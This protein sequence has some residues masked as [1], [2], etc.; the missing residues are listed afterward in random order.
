MASS[1]QT[2]ASIQRPNF[3]LTVLT[4]FEGEVPVGAR[5][6]LGRITDERTAKRRQMVGHPR[7]EKGDEDYF[8][9]PIPSEQFD[10]QFLMTGE[11]AKDIWKEEW[12]EAIRKDPKKGDTFEVGMAQAFF[13]DE[14]YPMVAT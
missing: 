2:L 4:Q 5:L 1:E 11:E 8:P 14:V 3:A 10:V 12:Y 13:K 9:T 6:G 7:F